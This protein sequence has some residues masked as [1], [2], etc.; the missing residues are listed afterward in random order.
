MSLHFWGASRGPRTPNRGL[1]GRLGPWMRCRAVGA[2]TAGMR[3]VTHT[4]GTYESGARTAEQVPLAGTQAPQGLCFRCWYR[5]GSSTWQV[6]GYLRRR[7]CWNQG[8]SLLWRLEW[9]KDAGVHS[10]WLLWME[11]QKLKTGSELLS[12]PSFLCL[13]LP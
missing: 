6:Q 12:P 9:P 3:C 2:C 5:K 1:S 10:F 4:A 7:W 13:P 8:R 11:A